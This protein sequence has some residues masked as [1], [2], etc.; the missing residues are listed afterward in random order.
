MSSESKIHEIEIGYGNPNNF[1]PDESDIAR[2]TLVNELCD[3]LQNYLRPI[4]NQEAGENLRNIALDVA[5]ALTLVAKDICEKRT[6]A[7]ARLVETR[8]RVGNL[9]RDQQIVIMGILEGFKEIGFERAEWRG[10]DTV[11]IWVT[12]Y[13]AIEALEKA[14]GLA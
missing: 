13:D 10:Q 7:K 9:T 8:Y 2:E 6:P 12:S 3:V 4:G 14:M 5:D 11:D 1:D